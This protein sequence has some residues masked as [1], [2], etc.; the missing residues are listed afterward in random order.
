METS[1]EHGV[2]RANFLPGLPSDGSGRPCGAGPGGGNGP[3]SR[4][5]PD[6]P[7]SARAGSSTP[8]PTAAVGACR[9]ISSTAGRRIGV[10]LC[11][12]PTADASASAASA[13]F[14]PSATEESKSLRRASTSRAFPSPPWRTAILKLPVGYGVRS[15]TDPLF[16]RQPLIP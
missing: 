12:S 7:M 2:F 16:C 8:L 15:D 9:L 1:G 3:N 6:A 5:S 14:F 11:G 10:L 4:I 13:S